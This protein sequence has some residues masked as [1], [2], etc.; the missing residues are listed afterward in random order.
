MDRECTCGDVEDEHESLTGSC[1]VDGC[2]CVAF[3]A[4]ADD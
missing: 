1:T 2:P 3:E 4:F